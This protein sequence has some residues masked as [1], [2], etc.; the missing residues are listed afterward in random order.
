MSGFYRHI[1]ESLPP[2]RQVL[3]A[4]FPDGL[5]KAGASRADAVITRYGRPLNNLCELSF[6]LA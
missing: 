4:T 3:I 5:L 6:S 2:K 1:D